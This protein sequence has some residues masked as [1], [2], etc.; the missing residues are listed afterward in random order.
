M[1]DGI[2]GDPSMDR[3][4]TTRICPFSKSLV[5]GFSMGDTKSTDFLNIE[6][7]YEFPVCNMSHN[8]PVD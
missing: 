5:P 4:M 7:C 8:V 3:K 1:P 2:C 6:P